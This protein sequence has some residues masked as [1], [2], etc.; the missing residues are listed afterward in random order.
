VTSWIPN[1]QREGLGS[2]QQQQSQRDPDAM[3]IDAAIVVVKE[4][5]QKDRK[6]QY[7]Q[8]ETK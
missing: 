7:E 5:A 4:L 6:W 1:R 2:P 8:R 3:D